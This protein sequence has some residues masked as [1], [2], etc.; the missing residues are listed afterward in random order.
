MNQG[1]H[2][3]NDIEILCDILSNPEAVIEGVVPRKRS[4]TMA[5]K[6]S[7]RILSCSRIMRFE[8]KW[9]LTL[10]WVLAIDVEYRARCSE[11]AFSEP[12]PET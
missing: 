3:I 6:R 8:S 5:R 7:G 4:V 9:I 2:R 12:V 10:A 1:L 11:P